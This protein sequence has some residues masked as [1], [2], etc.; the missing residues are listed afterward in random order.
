M[1]LK[2]RLAN[3]TVHQSLL[4]IRYCAQIKGITQIVKYNYIVKDRHIIT[5]NKNCK[6]NK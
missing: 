3:K 1:I 6:A 4:I 2:Y 5:E